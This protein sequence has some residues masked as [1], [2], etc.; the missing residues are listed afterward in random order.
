MDIK[1]P[2]VT[3]EKAF[4][5]FGITISSTMVTSVVAT[6]FFLIFVAAYNYIRSKNPANLFVTIIDV[7]VE[8]IVE[9][10]EGI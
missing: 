7:F 5:V 3:P 10:F 2:S 8:K 1:L 4:E 6:V 9:F